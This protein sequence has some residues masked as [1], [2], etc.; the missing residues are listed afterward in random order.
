MFGA[1]YQES[2]VWSDSQREKISLMSRFCRQEVAHSVLLLITPV[3][4]R[5][6]PSTLKFV[7]P[8]GSTPYIHLCYHCIPCDYHQM[9]QFY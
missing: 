8:L 4:L 7:P 1:I 9:A 2:A 3:L 5:R 6:S